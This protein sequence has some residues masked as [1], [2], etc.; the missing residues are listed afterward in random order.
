MATF[1]K[2]TFDAARYAAGT[3]SQLCHM[4]YI[5]QLINVGWTY[6]G[7]LREFALKARPT[8]PTQL[9]DFIFGF[10]AR[11]PR[12][13]WDTALDLGCGTGTYPLAFISSSSHPTPTLLQAKQPSS[14]SRASHTSSLS[15]PSSR[16]IAQ[17][18][19]SL[20]SDSQLKARVRF[21]Q[22]AAEEL[23]WLED[24]SVDMIVSGKCCGL[25]T[26]GGSDA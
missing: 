1:A 8:Y 24:G 20:D 18:T 19:K 2:K 25:Y 12:A 7:P 3:S 14:S 11:D 26:K 13:K 16:M 21:V 22:S 4:V 23:G 15:D 9:Y 10:H 6:V 5:L 17:A